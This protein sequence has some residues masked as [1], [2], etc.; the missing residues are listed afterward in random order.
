MKRA[1]FL[2]FVS[3]LLLAIA[4]GLFGCGSGGQLRSASEPES[5]VA[6]GSNARN[7]A[8]IHTELASLYLQ[9]NNMAVAL[10]EIRIS[11]EADKRYAPAY[12]VRGLIQMYLRENEAAEESFQR[13]LEL[14]SNDPEVNNNYGWFLCQTGREKESLAYFMSAI[15]N[16]LYQT[17]E[18]SYINAGIC[19]MRK[20]DMAAAEDFLQKAL[21]LSRNSPSAMLPLAQLNFQKGAYGESRRM[22]SDLHRQTEPTA[23]SLWLL[24]RVERKLGDRMGEAGSS[25]QL[26]RKFPESKEADDLRQGKFE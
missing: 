2:S 14:A 12:N 20:N 3:A 26:R 9:Q 11:L 22:L 25:S 5:T 4:F 1:A 10:E 17:P 16:T 19:S 13:A 7:R 18:K 8:R 15:K 23:E 21:R 6:S 24:V